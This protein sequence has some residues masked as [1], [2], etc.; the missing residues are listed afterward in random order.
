MVIQEKVLSPQEERVM[1]DQEEV[2]TSEKARAKR[3][4]VNRM[5][6]GFRA[7]PPRVAIDRARLYTESFKQTEGMPMMLSVAKAL[8]H[9]MSKIDIFIGDDELIV[10]HFGPPWWLGVLYPEYKVGWL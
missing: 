6:A 5:L 9:I 3:A 7:K 10:G 4:R 2:L 1:H 8:E